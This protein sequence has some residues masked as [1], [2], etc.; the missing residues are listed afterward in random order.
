MTRSNDTS[1]EMPVVSPEDIMTDVAN[2]AEA[3]AAA[4]QIF[5]DNFIFY[6]RS[7]S[8]WSDKLAIPVPD[9]K[10]LSPE[11]MRGLYVKLANNMQIVNHFFSVSNTISSTLV[12]GSQMKKA[13]LVR[14]IVQQY[15]K[16]N[17]T[18]PAVAAIEQMA[19]SYMKSTVSS[20]VSAKIVREFWRDRRDMLVE[21]RKTLEQI[22]MNMA[23]ELKYLTGETN[24]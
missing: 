16:E 6:G 7:L 5:I 19:D 9:A 10:N 1:E 20:R 18:R 15:E 8:E 11:V 17:K 24:D 23:T 2:A 13:D 21:L 14:Y 22:S 3:H 4:T 12:G